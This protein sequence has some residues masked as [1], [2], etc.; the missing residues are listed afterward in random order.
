MRIL[1]DSKLTVEQNAALHF[2]KAKKAR[3]K[4]EGA[5]KAIAAAESRAIQPKEE[6]PKQKKTVQRKKE[7]FEQFRWFFSSDNILCIGGRDAT[8][9]EMVVKKHAQPS[10]LAFHT[11]MAGSP[12]VIIQSEGKKIPQMT[13]EEAAQFTACHSRAWK[14]GMGYL[15]VFSAK[16]DQLS[17]TPNPG[18]FLPKGAFMVRGKVTYYSPRLELAVGKLPDGKIMIAP[19]TAIEEHCPEGWIILQGNEKTSDVA[20]EL[21]KKLECHPDELIPQL[22]AGGVKLGVKILGKS[23]ARR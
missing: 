19:R 4:M 13:I 7:W 22:P 20:K 12:F 2:E 17:K 3:K 16:P 23:H 6:K 8:T 1:L 10:D 11:D 15:E 5:R 21:A 14:Q 9:N 18:E